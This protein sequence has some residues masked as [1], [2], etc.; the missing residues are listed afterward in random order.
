MFHERPRGWDYVDVN[1]RTQGPEPSNRL[2]RPIGSCLSSRWFNNSYEGSRSAS[3]YVPVHETSGITTQPAGTTT[4]RFPK[5]DETAV[6]T[7]SYL[8][9]ATENSVCKSHFLVRG[10]NDTF[11]AHAEGILLKAYVCG[12][13]DYL[14]L[15]P[16]SWSPMI[17]SDK[18][19]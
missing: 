14:G 18:V 6:P 15:P 17:G 16:L 11:N 1:T 12:L 8:P 7:Y 5:F 19:K 4:T 13:H 10:T 9:T 2:L 3:Y